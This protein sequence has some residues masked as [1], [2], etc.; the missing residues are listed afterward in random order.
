MPD[1]KKAADAAFQR[2]KQDPRAVQYKPI[3]QGKNLKSAR[4]GKEGRAI[5]YE[6][7]GTVEW[8][9]IG[10]NHRDYEKAIARLEAL[11]Y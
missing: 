2:W 6:R 5:A 9:W 8:L 3:T 11:G 1:Q 4:I 7:G 10:F